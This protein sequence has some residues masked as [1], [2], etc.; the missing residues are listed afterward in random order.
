MRLP[1]SGGWR[2]A[3]NGIG[4][5]PPPGSERWRD[6][7]RARRSALDADERADPTWAATGND[8]WWVAYFQAQ[9]D[10]E[11]NITT[12]LVGRPNSWNKD[13]RVLFWGVPGR[14][15]ENVIDGIHNGAPR[16]ETPSSPLPSPAAR[17]QPRRKYSSSSKSSSSGL[18]RSTPS[19]SHRAAPYTVPKREVKEEPDVNPRGGGSG[20][21]QQQRR[22]ATLLIPKPE[23]KEEQDDE[24]AGKA[25]LLAQYERQQ[26]LIASS[27]DPEDCPGLRAGFLASLNDKD[28][29]R[30]DR[31]TAIAISIRDIGKPLADLTDDGEAGPSGLVKDEPIDEPDERV[32]QEVVTDDMYNFHQ[33]Y[34]A[35]AA[36][37][38]SRLGF[39]LNLI[40][41]RLNLCNIAS[42][43]EFA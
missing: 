19:S 36:T 30:G 11:M 22:S 34:D 24:A 6:S 31:D 15:L 3:F 43:N 10:M 5:P 9:Y 39:S 42:L 21:R 25:A 18:A 8:A 1:S 32:K 41:L 12:G 35:S 33:Y 26:G 14:T 17:W 16:L 2:M 27:D 38:T 40:K 29:W 7:I 4:I 13:G 37:S 28:A 23:V 20:S